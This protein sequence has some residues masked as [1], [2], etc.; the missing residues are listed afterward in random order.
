MFFGAYWPDPCVT[1][2]NN[3]RI[4]MSTISHNPIKQSNSGPS[5]EGNGNSGRTGERIERF[6]V[7]TYR[8]GGLVNLPER[9]ASLPHPPNPAG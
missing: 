4:F 7:K 2:E 5:A 1:A 9:R 3:F 6:V 8:R